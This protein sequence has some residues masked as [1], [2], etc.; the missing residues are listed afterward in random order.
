MVFMFCVY[1]LFVCFVTNL[2]LSKYCLAAEVRCLDSFF[3]MKIG[4]SEY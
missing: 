1:L 3:A 2:E 4:K